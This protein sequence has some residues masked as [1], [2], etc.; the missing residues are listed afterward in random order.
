MRQALPLLTPPC[1]SVLYQRL[2]RDTR[3]CGLEDT[4]RGL[5]MLLDAPSDLRCFLIVARSVKQMC[6]AVPPDWDIDPAFRNWLHL[7]EWALNALPTMGHPLR[8]YLDPP[9][10]N[11]G[12]PM[13]GY[14]SRYPLYS[15]MCN[16]QEVRACEIDFR[17]LQLQVLTTRAREL[18]QHKVQNG[19]YVDLYERNGANRDFAAQVRQPH[20][21][22]LA[23]RASSVRDADAL[24]HFMERWRP[25]DAFASLLRDRPD[26]PLGHCFQERITQIVNYCELRSSAREGLTRLAGDRISG[27]VEM[28]YGYVEYNNA[29]FG[30]ESDLSDADDEDVDEFG[31]ELVLEHSAVPD[32]EEALLCDAA[33][34][35]DAI[36][37]LVMVKSARSQS[38]VP[39]GSIARA[40][41]SILRLDIEREILPW[42]S[43][44][45]RVGEL[46]DTLLPAIRL[47]AHRGGA[48][49][50]PTLE[51]AALVAV[52]LETSRPLDHV[53]AMTLSDDPR[54]GLT[55][56]PRG[57]GAFPFSWC[58]EGIQ[59]LYRSELPY[60]DG[61]EVRRSPFIENPVCPV[62]SSLL[63]RW[64][65]LRKDKNRW[66]FTAPADEY[67]ARIR[68]WLTSL[69]ATRRVTITKI[70][71]LKWSILSQLTGGDFAQV[72]LVL[73]LPHPR[74]RVPLFYSLL[75]LAKA[76]RLF[77]EATHRIWVQEALS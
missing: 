37:S 45:L 65:Q 73:G 22:A 44:H 70:T 32:S 77:A 12:H 72:S 15:M 39:A 66:L 27:S 36:A 6:E 68:E 53:L 62:V 40:R 34:D 64:I 54:R 18:K 63:H 67:P 8:E 51:I 23:V 33:P 2:R 75:S 29:R 50:L 76:Q 10:T 4:F 41:T 14:M 21:A 61:K 38:G 69:D 11:A 52:C 26:A 48:A 19:P 3:L 24:V 25:P 9:K 46:E 59:P 58:W 43:A 5:C 31:H 17:L 60:V 57:E 71:R 30:V 7:V 42:S 74:S 49:D 13:Y 56:L 35:E 47:L 55:L 28:C 20:H 16:S 1:E